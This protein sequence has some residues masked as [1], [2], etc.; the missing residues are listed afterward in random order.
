MVG[1]DAE[2]PEGEHAVRGERAEHAAGHLGRYVRERVA[3]AQATKARVGER[4]DGIEVPARD[5]SKH[6]DDRVQPCCS[7][8]GVLQQLEADVAR[9]EPLCRDARADHEC[10]EER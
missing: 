5:R 8:G 7:G 9:R 3:P 10:G 6:Q 1:G 4:D 2:R